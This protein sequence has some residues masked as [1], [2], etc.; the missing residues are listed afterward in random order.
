MAKFIRYALTSFCFAV[1][2]SCLALWW[3]SNSTSDRFIGPTYLNPSYALYFEVSDG[4]VTFE[5][6][7]FAGVPLYA[8]E[9]VEHR[10]LRA[11]PLKFGGKDAFGANDNA[12]YF[13]LWYSALAFTL[14]GVG[15]LCFRRQFS[16]LSALI[17]VSVVAALLGMVVAF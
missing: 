16:I 5:A 7:N 2:V 17:W 15:V 4:S 12:I 14:V 9:R 8:F 1:S 3:R 6:I 11:P 13:P 10:P